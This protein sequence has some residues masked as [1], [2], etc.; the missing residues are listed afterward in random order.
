[1]TTEEWVDSAIRILDVLV[2]WPV[3]AAVML[4]IFRKQVSGAFRWLGRLVE[5]REVT[6]TTPI[7]SITLKRL[8]KAEVARAVK[9]AVSAAASSATRAEV[10]GADRI[11]AAARELVAQL[12]AGTDPTLRDL[13]SASSM[14][15]TF[16]EAIPEVTLPTP[17]DVTRALVILRFSQ[18]DSL[19]ADYADWLSAASA[20]AFEPGNSPPL[21]P[22]R[23]QFDLLA[24]AT[25]LGPT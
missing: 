8:G 15:L 19:P 12:R 21:L 24:E 10:P 7:G 4:I 5:K 20:L 22:S 14:G 2:A 11:A 16:A 13:A 17:D 25:S 18:S 6:A 9:D 1:M 23:L 3:F